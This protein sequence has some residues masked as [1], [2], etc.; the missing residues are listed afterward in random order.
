MIFNARKNNHLSEI[1]VYDPWSQS[2]QRT[3]TSTGLRSVRSQETCWCW[4]YWWLG[5]ERSVDCM[6]MFPG[7]VSPPDWDPMPGGQQEHRYLLPTLPPGVLHHHLPTC[8]DRIGSEID[9]AWTPLTRGGTLK[10]GPAK[11]ETGRLNS[12]KGLVRGWSSCPESEKARAVMRVVTTSSLS[13]RIS[14]P[15]PSPSQ[16]WTV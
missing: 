11:L 8:Q 9:P 15:P 5:V 6:V 4:F 14:P 10:W 16:G 12:L 7:L 3:I 13:G 2:D 1:F